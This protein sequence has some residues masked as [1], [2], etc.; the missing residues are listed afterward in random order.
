MWTWPETF[1]GVMMGS[2]L[3]SCMT[4]QSIRQKASTTRSP[5]T[6]VSKRVML[7]LIV[8][9]MCCCLSL[10]TWLMCE[11]SHSYI[12]KRDT[13]VIDYAERQMEVASSVGL[14]RA[15]TGV[16]MLTP[17]QCLLVQRIGSQRRAIHRGQG[18]G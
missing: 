3:P 15:L 8:A 11:A 17:H 12:P 18:E 6:S 14:R 16:W 1:P 5:A 4:P 7:R 2:T 10:L 13:M 9:M